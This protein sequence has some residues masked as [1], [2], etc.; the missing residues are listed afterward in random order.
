[1]LEARQD[2]DYYVEYARTNAARLGIA[3]SK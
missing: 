2:A 3:P 1:L